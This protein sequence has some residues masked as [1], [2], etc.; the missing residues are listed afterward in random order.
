MKHLSRILT[1][2]LLTVAMPSFG[3][4]AVDLGLP[5]GTK[6]ADRNVGAFSPTD[7]GNYYAWGEINPKSYYD[8]NT[9]I[10]YDANTNRDIFIGHDIAGTQ[11]DVARMQWG[12]PWKMP[13]RAQIIELIRFCKYKKKIIKGVKGYEFKGPNGNSIFLPHAGFVHCSYHKFVDVSGRLRTTYRSSEIE[14]GK[15]EIA[16]ERGFILNYCLELHQHH[17]MDSSQGKYN[18]Y[19][20]RPVQ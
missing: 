2:A 16:E 19:S 10:H 15:G 12:S 9:Y 4:V 14:E 3:Q 18:G 13:T 6:W 8:R 5:S 1:I 17:V 7:L 20:V 11:Y